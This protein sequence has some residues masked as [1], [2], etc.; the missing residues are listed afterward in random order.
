LNAL[1]GPELGVSK[2]VGAGERCYDD[3]FLENGFNF[4]FLRSPREHVLSQFLECR[5]SH[6][7]VQRTLG[8]GFPSR[9]LVPSDVEAFERWVDYFAEF[10]V[11]ETLVA[12][13]K[14]RNQQWRVLS[15]ACHASYRLLT[16]LR[17]RRWF[18]DFQCY[19]PINRVTRQFTLGCYQCAAAPVRPSRRRR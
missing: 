16:V 2:Q 7:A 15:G 12:L 18:D 13:S 1:Y 17:R 5:Y 19:N 3:I 4:V 11:N 6:W 10:K 8:T 14:K 9:E